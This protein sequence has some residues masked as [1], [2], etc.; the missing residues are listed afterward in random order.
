MNVLVNI[1]VK[2]I[3]CNINILVKIKMLVLVNINALINF[4]D[5]VNIIVKIL[6]WFFSVFS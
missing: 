2:L 4:N 6:F 3:F 1:I 5:L